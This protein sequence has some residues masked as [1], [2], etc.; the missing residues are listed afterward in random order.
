VSLDDEKLDTLLELIQ[1]SFRV[2]PNQD[3]V[4]VDVGRHLSR[5]AAPQHQVIF[6][7][8]G[9]GKSCLLVHFYRAANSTSGARSIY[10]DCDEVKRLS[11]P[12]LLIRLLLM[13]LEEMP[14]SHRKWWQRVWKRP[15]GAETSV[16]ELRGLLDLAEDSAVTEQTTQS[17]G[18]RIEA[19]I[20]APKLAKVGSTVT[21]EASIARTSSFRQRK[22]ELLERHFSDYKRALVGALEPDERQSVIFDDFY[23]IHLTVQPDVLDYI[24][25]LLR[26]TS[27]YF[28][29]GTVRHRTSLSRIEGQ[30]IGVD[31]Y[32]DIEAID[33]DRTFEDTAGTQAYLESMLDSMGSTVGIERASGLYLSEEGRLALA[34]ASG[35]VPR[36]YL[37]TFSEAVRAAREAGERKW[38][39]PKHVYTGAGRVFDR[40]KF[41]NLR[42]DVGFDATPLERVFQDLLAFCLTEK[43]KTAFLIAQSD[44]PDHSEE[45]ELIQQLMDFKLIHVIVPDTSA[46]S[47]R[48]GRFEAYTLDF[49]LFMNPR[50]RNI[51]HVQFWRVDNQRRREGVREAP[52]YD[53]DRARKVLLRATRTVPTEQIVN[54]IAA[55]VGSD[56]S[57]SDEV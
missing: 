47:G 18:A 6:G 24:H 55:S 14:A 21:T 33:L 9:S 15:S 54:E 50:L 44:V 8:R 39:T 53:L 41:N 42:S 38:L 36:D 20:E 45:H 5:V 32:Q 31:E 11:Y 30:P 1:N 51:E 25:R 13:I 37:S 28:K 49:A 29:I 27:L 26:G 12:D 17:I 43:R 10:I 57:R 3:P 23:L 56:A 22:L 34:L 46:A 2:R 4:Y 52:V 35:G 48:S 40:T 7:R 19:G 16:R